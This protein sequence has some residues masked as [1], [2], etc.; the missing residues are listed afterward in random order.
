LCSNR[1]CIPADPSRLRAF[2]P[3]QTEG[4]AY[5]NQA[6]TVFG[7]QG[8]DGRQAFFARATL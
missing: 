7:Y 5:H 3:I 1:L 8:S 2:R 6:D 4:L